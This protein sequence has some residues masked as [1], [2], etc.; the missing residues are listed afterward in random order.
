MNEYPRRTHT[1]TC[2]HSFQIHMDV[3]ALLEKGYAVWLDLAF[4]LIKFSSTDFLNVFVGNG[5]EET[6]HEEV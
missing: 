3:H 4:I 5:S 1:L 2:K 6:L